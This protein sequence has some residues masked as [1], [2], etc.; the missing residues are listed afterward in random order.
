MPFD[1]YWGV[2]LRM[3]AMVREMR[4]SIAGGRYADA[5]IALR[6]RQTVECLV[7][8][9]TNVLCP[10]SFSAPLA[11]LFS[12]HVDRVRGV[13][14]HEL[15][16][17]LIEEHEMF[18]VELNW[19]TQL[20]RFFDVVATI[21][22]HRADA[23]VLF[24]GLYAALKHRVV[25]ERS[26]VDY[27]I[28]GDNELPIRMLLDD[29]P[30]E[31]IPNL[32]S[33]DSENEQTYFFSREEFKTLD[34]N[35]D[36]FPSAKAAQDRLVS[37]DIDEMYARRCPVYPLPVV[38]TTKGGCLGCHR[39]CET[40][41][42]SHHSLLRSIYGREIIELEGE[43]LIDLFKKVERRFRAASFHVLSSPNFDFSGCSFDLDVFIE[44]NGPA[45][46]EQVART[47]RA[48]RRAY[49]HLFVFD[50]GLRG[51]TVRQ[52]IRQLLALEDESHRIFFFGEV[53]HKD[54]PDDRKL[55]GDTAMPEWV[56]YNVYDDFDK[57]LRIAQMLKLDVRLIDNPLLRAQMGELF[58]EGLQP[59]LNRIARGR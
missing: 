28:R 13:F 9:P 58:F 17:E 3:Q 29:A 19:F 31:T 40:C 36:W 57:A 34:F 48:F 12:N 45:S 52:D 27:F 7:I 23:K 24:G 37:V 47:I 18:V 44:F 59:R 22:R 26:Q 2:R 43:I 55:Y 21:R 38:F 56:E 33:R 5:G 14:D 49:V 25:F 4:V 46:V 1:E 16:R 10:E 41:L 32:V 42:G 53:E 6:G 20:E 8:V 15:T 11:W 39:G 30:I 51:T 50:E 35:L 54:I